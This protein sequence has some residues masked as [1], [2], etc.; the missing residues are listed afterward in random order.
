ME[1]VQTKRKCLHDCTAKI[2]VVVTWSDVLI[3]CDISTGK[4]GEMYNV[5]W[6]DLS[7]RSCS[8][9]GPSSVTL[10]QY[11]NIISSMANERMVQPV[12]VIWRLTFVGR[13]WHL[14]LVIMVMLWHLSL[15]VTFVEAKLWHLS[16]AVT[17]VEAKLWH[18]SLAVPFVEAKLCHL[19][20]AVTCVEAKLWHLSRAVTFVEAMLWH[21]SLAVT[22]VEGCCAICRGLWHLVGLWHLSAQQAPSS[23]AVQA[24]KRHLVEIIKGYSHYRRSRRTCRNPSNM[25]KSGLPPWTAIEKVP[26]PLTEILILGP[27][28]SPE[29]FSTTVP[30]ISLW[31]NIVF[32]YHPHGFLW[33]GG[34]KLILDL[35]PRSTVFIQ[36]LIQKQCDC[37][38]HCILYLCTCT[39]PTIH[40]R[41]G[42]HHRG[43]SVCWVA[44]HHPPRK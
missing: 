31:I 44:S 20:L 18:L 28:L 41:K 3:C 17:F 43:I 27:P 10:D 9:V 19:S 11:R 12:Q 1:I 5:R 22:F 4:S 24:N 34:N 23:E 25:P 21:L 13:L 29:F 30:G 42:A 15:A 40:A 6:Y 36:F 33:K 16:L 37:H 35:I 8:A 32:I 26:P 7:N 2:V 39:R 38:L 14:S